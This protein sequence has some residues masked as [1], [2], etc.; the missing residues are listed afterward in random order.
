M[1]IMNIKA[2]LNIWDKIGSPLL[3]QPKEATVFKFIAYLLL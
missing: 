1:S 2:T 3:L